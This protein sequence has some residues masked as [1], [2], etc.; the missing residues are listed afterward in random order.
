M[1]SSVVKIMN[2]PVFQLTC[3]SLKALLLLLTAIYSHSRNPTNQSDHNHYVIRKCFKV[4][5]Q[6]LIN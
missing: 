4:K 5:R 2:L 1:D 3:F 6:Q